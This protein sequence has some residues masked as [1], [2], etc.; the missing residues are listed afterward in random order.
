MIHIQPS[1]THNVKT[2]PLLPRLLRAEIANIAIAAQ[3]PGRLVRIDDLRE[4]GDAPDVRVILAPIA[5][6]DVDG[7]EFRQRGLISE[8]LARATVREGVSVKAQG[9]LCAKDDARLVVVAFGGHVGKGGDVEAAERWDDCGVVCDYETSLVFWHY[10]GAAVAEPDEVPPIAV[11]GMRRRAGWGACHELTT[12]RKELELVFEGDVPIGVVFDYQGRSE[13]IRDYAMEG[14]RS[15][16]D[17]SLLYA[18]T[19][20]RSLDGHANTRLRYLFDLGPAHVIS[21]GHNSI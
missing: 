8:Q 13:F 21:V 7:F 16:S 2:E 12:L 3:P 5:D 15:G 6:A 18:L 17:D 9:P 1:A 11:R 14:I 19:S 10:V 4:D 20:G